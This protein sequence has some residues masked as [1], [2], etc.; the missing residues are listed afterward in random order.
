LQ[1]L[2]G[3]RSLDELRRIY[4]DVWAEGEATA[5]L[6]ALFPRRPSMLVPLD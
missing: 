6:N 3:Y 2:F 5:L 1:L 4:P